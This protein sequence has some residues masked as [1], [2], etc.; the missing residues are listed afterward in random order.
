MEQGAED[1]DVSVMEVSGEVLDEEE[2]DDEEVGEGDSD[3]E[4]EGLKGE[5]PE[6]VMVQLSDGNIQVTPASSI[7]D[8]ER[9]FICQV[10]AISKL[11]Q[12]TWHRSAI[13]S[14]VLVDYCVKYV[15]Q[16]PFFKYAQ[17]YPTLLR[18]WIFTP[19][20]PLGLS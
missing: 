20:S 7:V 5:V 9:K 3:Q 10:R 13:P 19:F 8:E 1:P 18:S 14:L 17:T 12:L 15:H 11:F 4:D 6:M 16:D 2:E